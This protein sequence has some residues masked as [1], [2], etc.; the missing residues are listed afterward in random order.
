M[1]VFHGGRR[2]LLA[3]IVVSGCVLGVS[4]QTAPPQTAPAQAAPSQTELSREEKAQFLL[5]AR[6]TSSQDIHKGITNPVRLTLTNGTVTHAA[7]FSTVDEHIGVMKFSSGRTELDFVDSYKYSVA[8]Y[9][10]AVL[11]G[12]DDMMPVTV[13]REVSHHKGSLSWWVDFKWHEGDRL[14]QKLEA[15]DPEA[16]NQQ[17]FR[18]RVFTQLV[19]DTD[20][21]TGNV[22]ITSDWKLWMI[23][24]TR[25][26]RRT[27]QLLAPGDVTRCD[28]RLLERLRALTKEDVAEKTKP[29][30][31]GS[32]IDAMMARRDAIIA[33]VEKQVAARGEAQVLY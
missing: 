4:A 2:A 31:G 11:L 5:T 18:M 3:A 27:H 15:P 16:W 14:K 25:A 6:I 8:A 19:A 29:F 26:F 22:L 30:I 20:R 9:R 32:E 23:D 28:R 33:L 1:A 24:F 21:N 12:I 10:L 13:E 17:M 7:A